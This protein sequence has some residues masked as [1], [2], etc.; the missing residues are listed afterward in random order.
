MP[1]RR[2]ALTMVLLGSLALVV[3][4]L[5]VLVRVPGPDHHVP[6]EITGFGG[7]LDGSECY[8]NVSYTVD[9]Q[10]FRMKT[11]PASGG[12]GTATCSSSATSESRSTTT[13]Q[14]QARGRLRREDLGRSAPLRS[15]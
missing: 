9:G 6:G 12:A 2:S 8:M 5:V 10:S 11:Y 13:R 14:P 15:V 1:R 3:V 7:K 4:G